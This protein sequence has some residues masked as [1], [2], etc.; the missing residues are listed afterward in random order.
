MNQVIITGNVC[1][2]A[3]VHVTNDGVKKASFLLAVNRPYAN[4]QGNREADFIPIV[5]WKER[6]EFAEKYI[7]KGTKLGVVGKLQVRSYDAQDGSKRHVTE[8][9]ADEMEFLQ[10]KSEGVQAGTPPTRSEV[11]RA[12]E[13][14]P[15]DD[16]D[17][18]PF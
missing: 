1:K 10:S 8:V 15:A 7:K 16:E 12:A 9:V 17:G 3:E 4:R 6:A 13:M 14:T 11:K 2:D 5:A 18:L